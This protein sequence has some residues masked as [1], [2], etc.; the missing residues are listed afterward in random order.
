[1]TAVG[2]IP[3]QTP[4][5]DESSQARKD[6]AYLNE[7]DKYSYF[8]DPLVSHNMEGR[9]AYLECARKYMKIKKQ[10]PKDVISSSYSAFV[11]RTGVGAGI[12]ETLY[13]VPNT[14]PSFE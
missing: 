4:K 5:M 11:V 13:N 7:I 14:L 6:R 8:V 10:L 12:Y 9:D 1:M 3:M 2:E